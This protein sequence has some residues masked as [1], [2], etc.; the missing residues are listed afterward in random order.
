[1]TKKEDCGTA[2]QLK[3]DSKMVNSRTTPLN[4]NNSKIMEYQNKD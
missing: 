3:R 4:W 2:K 1:M